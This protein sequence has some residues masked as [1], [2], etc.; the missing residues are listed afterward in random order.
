MKIKRIRTQNYRGKNF[1]L[2]PAK[3]NLFFAKNGTGKTSLCDAV[4]YGI[5]GLVPPDN[6]HSGAVQIIFDNGMS[7]QR[8]RGKATVCGMNGKKV[9][10]TAMNEAIADM[11]GIPI[12]KGKRADVLRDVKIACSSDVLLQ[13]SPADFSKLLMQYIPET[14]DVDRILA[15]F[16]GQ[17]KEVLDECRKAFPP[18]PE[19]FGMKKVQEVYMHYFEDRKTV[20]ALLK[21]KDAAAKNLT[22]T[23]PKRTAEVISEELTNLIAFE[24]TR[25]DSI[26]RQAEYA[27]AKRKR[28]IQE[29]EIR[30]LKDRI[31]TAPAKPDDATGER[32]EHER[33]TLE[34]QIVNKTAQA[35]GIQTHIAFFEKELASLDL[36]VCPISKKLV[37]TTDKTQI[38]TE[39]EAMLTQNKEL[40]A[41]VRKEIEDAKARK[42]ACIRSKKDYDAA[43]S[44]YAE[45][46][47]LQAELAAYEKNL[48]TLPDKPESETVNPEELAKKKRELEAE[49]KNAEDYAYKQTLLK[50][51]ETQKARYAVETG[52]IRALE[53]KGPVRTKIIEFYLQQFEG[54][55]NARAAQFAPGYIF[56]FHPDNGVK[57]FVKTPTMQKRYYPL[58]SCSN[59]EKVLAS[60]ILTDMVNQLTGSRL[61]FVDNLEAMDLE[62]MQGLRKLLETPE[63]TA[64]YD[65]I[66]LCGVNHLDVI[67]T[68]MGM[69]NAKFIKLQEIDSDAKN[70]ANPS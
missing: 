25:M 64:E 51:A 19:K 69:K 53:D 34:G 44:A 50:E 20:N 4:R 61:M 70:S 22:P 11:I 7:I 35:N 31:S 33:E 52:M 18:M 47:K 29:A 6:L 43:K 46:A 9:T 58:A 67:K 32:L 41:D 40:L 5:T 54:V 42:E 23:E 21:E 12:Q 66:F 63:F 39:T 56:K 10:E 57:I 36:P 8:A 48:V 59:G 68:F 1:D 2:E 15:Y 3:I 30:R 28:E 24:R 37:C 65:H 27:S 55:C 38:R 45:Y 49:K 26:K 62:H 17:P 13:L 60:F 14:L 16:D